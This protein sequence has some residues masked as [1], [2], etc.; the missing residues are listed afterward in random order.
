MGTRSLIS[1]DYAVKRLL[2]NKADYEILEGFLSELFRRQIGIDTIL[3]SESNREAEHDR[4]NR[5]DLLAG[6][7]SGELFIIELQFTYEI[8]YFHRMLFGASKVVTEYIAEGNPYGEI[9]KVY[10]VNIVYFDLGMGKDYVYYGKTRFTGMHEHDELQLSASQRE[11]FGK[12]TAGDL[13]PEYYIL[14]VNKFD[15]VAGDTLDEWIYYLKNS[16]IK[17]GF[18]AQGLKKA[19]EVLNVGCL[20]NE[21]RKE[22]ERM[23]DA[24]RSNASSIN[25]A[26]L[27]GREEGREEGRAEGK[28]EGQAELV[29]HIAKTGHSPE[30]I[31]GLTGLS[32]EEV[33][34][35]LNSH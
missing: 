13:F 14:K 31:A 20:T 33:I 1:F 7:E 11:T 27:E 24:H 29:K 26:K 17:D 16:K 18:K 6:D 21:E 23:L 25:S 32:L 10:S 2:R 8:D 3:E 12:Q 15:N 5:V 9:R 22:Y 4:S 19:Q 35:I 34:A 30:N 28:A